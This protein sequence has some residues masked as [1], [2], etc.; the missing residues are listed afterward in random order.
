VDEAAALAATIAPGLEPEDLAFVAGVD[1]SRLNSTTAPGLQ[2]KV[3]ASHHWECLNPAL[4]QPGVTVNAQ[5]GYAD[6]ATPGCSG[7][8]IKVG[9][10]RYCSK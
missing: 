7:T 4:A 1:H 8:W 10:S 2:L 5:T 9:G 3:C 6:L